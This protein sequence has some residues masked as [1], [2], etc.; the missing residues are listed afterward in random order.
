MPS[1]H[2]KSHWLA[3]LLLSA[4]MALGTQALAQETPPDPPEEPDTFSQ[5]NRQVID[6]IATTFEDQFESFEEAQ[7]AVEGLVTGDLTFSPAE[8][9]SEDPAPEPVVEDEI[10]DPESDGRQMGF[11]NAFTTLAL[12]TE[13]FKNEAIADEFSDFN[14]AINEILRLR[15]EE[16][17]GWGE[18]AHQYDFKLGHVMSSYRSRGGPK[19]NPTSDTDNS[20]ADSTEAS[21]NDSPAATSPNRS[22]SQG[23]GQRPSK[24]VKAEKADRPEHGKPDKI[25]KFSKP[26]RPEKPD[27]PEKP[28]R[29]EKPDKPQR[30][31]R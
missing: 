29:P 21:S 3:T 30:N 5:G 12:A 31:G 9:P 1:Q 16:E 20:D 18:I 17:M 15:L 19:P 7:T 2:C 10:E 8:E 6:R 4:S 22:P 27:R 13:I 24:P 26:E 11:G 28:N 14:E 23:S 25:E